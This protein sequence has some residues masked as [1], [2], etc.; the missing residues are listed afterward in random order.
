MTA[1]I[2]NN[3]SLEEYATLLNLSVS[4]FKRRFK[5]IYQTSPG[6]YIN[7]KKLEKA[8][9]LLSGS[10]QRIGEICYDCGFGDVSNFTKAFKARLGM[11]PSEYQKAN[12]T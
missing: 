6:Q 8:A 12:A 10:T 3:L 4:T 11:T 5:E 7:S 2:F 9:S 1:H